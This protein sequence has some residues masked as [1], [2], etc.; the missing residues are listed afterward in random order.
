VSRGD[1]CSNRNRRIYELPT[2]ITCRVAGVILAAGSSSRIGQ[3]KQLLPYRGKPILDWVV[4]NALRSSL[5]HV[6]VVLG[7][8]VEQIREAVDFRDVSVVVNQLHDQGQSTSLR[9]GL[10]AVPADAVGVMFILADQPRVSPQI[11]NALIE[12]Y[13]RTKAP[14]VIPTYRSRRGN[15]VI[16]DRAFFGRLESLAGDVGARVLFEEYAEQIEEIEIED[17]SI[18][19]DLDTWDDYQELKDREGDR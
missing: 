5:H 9:K 19:C 18:H 8:A 15:P 13:C 11:I 1:G 12:G 4:E 2:E 7:H 6:V 10:A 3:V 16:I 14:I 17:D